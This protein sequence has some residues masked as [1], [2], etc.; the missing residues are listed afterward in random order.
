MVFNR[1][2]T[3]NSQDIVD[4]DRKIILSKNIGNLNSLYTNGHR[5]THQMRRL[6]VS[7]D[8]CLET[9]VVA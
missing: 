6:K 3:Y 8:R 5:I 1:E 2:N 4:T 7:F 9:D